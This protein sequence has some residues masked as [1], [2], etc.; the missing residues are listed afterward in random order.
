[1][2]LWKLILCLTMVLTVPMMFIACD[3]FAPDSGDDTCLH[4]DSDNNNICDDCG[5]SL[6]ENPPCDHVDADDNGLCDS[7]GEEFEDGDE[8]EDIFDD[9]EYSF[10]GDGEDAGDLLDEE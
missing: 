1:M 6:G 9:E 2:K 10:D 5:E 3:F 7:C 4:N 8:V